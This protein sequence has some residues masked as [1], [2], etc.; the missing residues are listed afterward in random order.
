MAYGDSKITDLAAKTTPA[1]SDLAYIV[2]MSGSPASKKATLTNVL[3]KATGLGDGFPQVVSGVMQI[4]NKM[5]IDDATGYVT[6]TG[7]VTVDELSLYSS[8]PAVMFNAIWDNGDSRS[9][10]ITNDSAFGIFHDQDTEELLF[11]YEPDIGAANSEAVFSTAF[12]IGNDGVTTFTGAISATSITAA[13]SE[14]DNVVAYFENTHAGGYGGF[15]V[16]NDNDDEGFIVLGGTT[17]DWPSY[18]VLGASTANPTV[19]IT[20]NT[21]RMGITAGGLVGIGD[22]PLNA[23]ELLHVEDSSANSEPAIQIENDA[24]AWKIEV[25]GGDS[26]KYKL[27]DVTDANATVFE[28]ALGTQYVTFT[29]Q[30][31][32]DELSLYSSSPAVMFN[33]V[34]DNGDFR[35]EFITNDSAF[36]I[37]HDQTTEELLFMYEPDIGVAGEEAAFSTAMIIDI[38]GNVT[39][40]VMTLL[41]SELNDTSD[42]HLL[43]VIE[44][45]NTIITNSESVGADEWDFPAKTEGWNFT[46]IKEADQNI[47]LDP[48]GAENWWFRTNDLAYTQNGAG[49]SIDNTTAGKSTITCFSTESGVYCDGD[50]NWEQG[51]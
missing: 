23:A 36:G 49:T 1:S 38:Y 31:T 32:A 44:L 45:K 14:D 29:G 43:T 15:I 22:V 10:F 6:F 37:Y 33:S 47:V 48:N 4:S 42:A 16:Y 9:E 21:A 5:T 40:P 35:S 46:F 27:V 41:A 12:A 11:L 26:D 24:Q 17:A 7:Q 19:F 13:V 25:D 50:A 20:T 30:V 3:L 28:V 39:I 34:W 51:S 18:F 8:T 2:D